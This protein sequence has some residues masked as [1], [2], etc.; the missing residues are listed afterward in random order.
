MEVVVVVVEDHSLKR[1][2]ERWAMSELV[3][4]G[5]RFALNFGIFIRVPL[6]AKELIPTSYQ[7]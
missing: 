2:L 6:S 4:I 3:S 1:I 5:R 7:M